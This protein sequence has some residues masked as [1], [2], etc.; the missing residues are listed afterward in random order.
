VTAGCGMG[1]GRSAKLSAMASEDEFGF[2]LHNLVTREDVS[3]WTEAEAYACTV[4]FGEDEDWSLWK[5]R[6]DGRGEPAMVA[7]GCG[8][9]RP[10]DIQSTKA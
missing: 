9:V 10:P 8:P 1:S 5:V 6:R 4:N 3:T 7:V 2:V